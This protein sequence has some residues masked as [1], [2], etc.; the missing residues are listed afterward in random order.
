MLDTADCVNEN[1]NP[2][3]AT[4]SVPALL[5]EDWDYGAYQRKQWFLLF[6]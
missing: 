6:S 2:I 4:S 1:V 3:A 5:S